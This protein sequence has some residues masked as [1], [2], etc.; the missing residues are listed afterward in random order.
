MIDE[1]IDEIYGSYNSYKYDTGTICTMIILHKYN[2]L[3]MAKNLVIMVWI[4]VYLYA[5][6]R[7]QQ[8]EQ[9]FLSLNR[10]TSKEQTVR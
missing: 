8:L 5:C 9:I 1:I 7:T 3:L 2:Y 10:L 4:S 6:K